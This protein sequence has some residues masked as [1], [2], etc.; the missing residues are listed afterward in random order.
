MS[1][2][3]ENDKQTDDLEQ[4]LENDEKESGDEF[5]QDEATGQIN[6]SAQ[7]I[8]D[9]DSL[10]ANMAAGEYA[11]TG[12]HLPQQESEQP[13][14]DQPTAKKHKF[15]RR[16][17]SDCRNQGNGSNKQQQFSFSRR[18][19]IGFAVFFLVCSAATAYIAATVAGNRAEARIE[20]LLAETD[21]GVIYRSV[22]TTINA[23]STT[24]DP[25]LAVADTVKLA[26]D[27]VVEIS[28]KMVTN[29]FGFGESVSAGAGSGV[30]ISDNGYIVTNNHVVADAT[31]IQVILRNGDKYDA[32]LVGRDATADIAVLKIEGDNL[33]PAV[34]GSSDALAVG[35]QVVAIGNPLGSLGGTVT[36]GYVSA[37][38]R[39]IS[40]EG[41]PMTLLQTDATIN[42]G[43]SGGGLFNDH[44][45]LVGIAVAYA[46]GIGV[47]GLNFFIPVDDINDVISD[48]LNYGY[49]RNRISLGVYLLDINDERTANSYQV[50]EM[51]VYILGYTGENTNAEQDGL[52]A[53][54]RVVSIDGQAVEVAADIQKIIQSHSAN[55]VI[56]VVVQRNG[57]DK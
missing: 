40:I 12:D 6:Q 24:A 54:D 32:E 45:E 9:N 50:D 38:D 37:K 17:G 23:A 36:V 3:Q 49:V 4:P 27:S 14:G 51:G 15:F 52:V 28:T 42:A 55:D 5:C 35:D 56:T 48:L 46:S 26:A 29:Y 16:R 53:G 25:A 47:Q 44:G 10:T 39:E 41:K 19:I 11:L 33:T 34:F 18:W 13:R 20:A 2:Y 43:N 1:F 22:E 31:A 30:I 8:V 7:N 57:A 21:T